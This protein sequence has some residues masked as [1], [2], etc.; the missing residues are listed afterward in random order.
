MSLVSGIG[1]GEEKMRV[2]KG[3]C[4]ITHW[5][6]PSVKSVEMDPARTLLAS[7]KSAEDNA[8]GSDEKMTYICPREK[9]KEYTKP[10]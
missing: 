6:P 10:N 5:H 8:Y 9:E 3:C 1:D 7:P 2:R 4:C